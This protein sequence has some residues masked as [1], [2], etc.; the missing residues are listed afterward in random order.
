M[1][2]RVPRSLVNRSAASELPISSISNL[3]WIVKD[4]RKNREGKLQSSSIPSPSPAPNHNSRD[5][6]IYGPWSQTEIEIATEKSEKSEQ[7]R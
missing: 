3:H 7:S 2:C 1:I 5:P 6:K 4:L